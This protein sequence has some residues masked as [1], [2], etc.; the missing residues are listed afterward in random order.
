MMGFNILHGYFWR[1]PVLSSACHRYYILIY[2]DF[3]YFLWMLPLTNK[4]QVLEMFTSLSNQIR[5]QFSQ[6]VKCF[7]YDNG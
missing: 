5:T 7:Q 6:I 2:D 4:S 1:S 3:T